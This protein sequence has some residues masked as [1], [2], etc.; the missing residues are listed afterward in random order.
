MNSIQL[1]H[2]VASLPDSLKTEVGDFI[3]FLLTKNKKKS[4]KGKPSFGS[5]K[6]IFVI[7]PGFDDPLKDFKDYM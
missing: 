6:G 7:K 5:G 3:D 2:K 1:Y 4:K